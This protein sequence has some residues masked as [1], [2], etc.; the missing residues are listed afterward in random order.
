MANWAWTQYVVEG[1]KKTLNKIEKALKHPDVQ[2]NSSPSWEGNV[3]R[4]LKIEWEQ[5]TSEDKGS[6][7]SKYMRGFIA[8]ISWGNKEH[9]L[10]RFDAEEAWGITD[11]GEVLEGA[12][13]DIKIYYESE[14]PGMGIFITND[15]DGKYF[16]D[17]FYADVCINGD[18]YS[19]YFIKEEEMYHCISKW[20]NGKINNKEE[21]ERFNESPETNPDDFIIIIPIKVV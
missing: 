2:E 13:K 19:D 8:E 15:K 17:R 18:Y 12:F 5:K 14:E 9:T 6:Y 7:S 16:K 20:S 21:V 3:L 4:A 1:P 10:L 11:F